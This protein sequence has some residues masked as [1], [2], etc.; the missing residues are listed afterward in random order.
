LIDT[1]KAVIIFILAVKIVFGV[2]NKKGR[3]IGSWEFGIWDW[4]LGIR[5]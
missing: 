4:Q 3:G 2:G 5:K 1:H